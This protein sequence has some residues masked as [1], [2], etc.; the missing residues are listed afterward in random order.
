MIRKLA[1]GRAWLFKIME[2]ARKVLGKSP[3]YICSL[4]RFWKTLFFQG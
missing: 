2:F 1:L 4:H 3:I